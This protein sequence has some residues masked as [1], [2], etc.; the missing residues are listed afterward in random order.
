MP[1]SEGNYRLRVLGE[2]K[3]DVALR[4]FSS[5]WRLHARQVN[6]LVR[7]QYRGTA[8]DHPTFLVMEDMSRSPPR[9]MGVCAWRLRPLGDAPSPGDDNDHYLH[10]IGVSRRYRGHVLDNYVTVGTVLLG[11]ALEQVETE[12]GGIMPLVWA[13]IAPS[14]FRSHRLFN[15]HDFDLFKKHRGHDIRFRDGGLVLTPFPTAPGA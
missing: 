9:T 4:R 15:H 6:K 11:A 1:S 3:K 10:V 8:K 2:A 14:N 7:K 12:C 13:F 5:G